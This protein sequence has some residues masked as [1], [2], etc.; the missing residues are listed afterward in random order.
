MEARDVTLTRARSKD[1][2]FD[3]FD[4]EGTTYDAVGGFP[5]KFLDAQWDAFIGQI[6][7]HLGKADLI[8]VDVSRFSPEQKARVQ[9]AVGH[10]G[11]RIFIVGK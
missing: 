3:W 9:K 5:G 11:P 2:N 6:Y 8:P 10:L 4:E 7:R 1:D